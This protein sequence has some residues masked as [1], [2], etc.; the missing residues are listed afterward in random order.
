M[1]H[2]RNSSSLETNNKTADTGVW[3][4][5]LDTDLRTSDTEVAFSN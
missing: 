4:S 1:M 3:N 2:I 5:G